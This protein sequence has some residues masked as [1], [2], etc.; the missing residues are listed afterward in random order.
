ME[1]FEYYMSYNFA[2]GKMCKIMFN[3]N[4]LIKLTYFGRLNNF[5]EM[6][7]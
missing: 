5:M 2:V 4:C 6:Y 1:N 7:H 3:L